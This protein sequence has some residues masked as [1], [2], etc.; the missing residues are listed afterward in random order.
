MKK[1]LIVSL[2]LYTIGMMVILLGMTAMYYGWNPS[3]WPTFLEVPGV[4]Y[5]WLG[6]CINAGA[7]CGIASAVK[8]V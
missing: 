7:Y 4:C 5:V 8:E 6:L 2:V 1:G 3:W